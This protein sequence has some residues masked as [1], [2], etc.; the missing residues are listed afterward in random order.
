METNG[1]EQKSAKQ[2]IN[3][4]FRLLSA[5]AI[6]SVVAGHLGGGGFS[7]LYRLFPAYQFHLAT[8]IFISGY[9]YQ[10]K[11]E[12][13][14]LAYIKKKFWH[15][16]VPMYLW[17]LFYGIVVNVLK[18]YDLVTFGEALS[19]KTLVIK[20]LYH[21]HQFVLDLA[22]W[23]VPPLF[24]AEVFTVL[25]RRWLNARSI[26]NEYAIFL[27]YLFIGIVG[28]ELAIHGLNTKAWLLICKTCIFI[29]FFGIGRMYRTKWEQRE[30]SSHVKY[31]AGIL[32]MQIPLRWYFQTYHNYNLG[33]TLS[34]CPSKEFILLGP[35]LPF[36]TATFGVLFW[37]R[38]CKIV[39]PWLRRNWLLNQMGE[40]TFAIMA[41]HLMGAMLVKLLLAAIV[42]LFGVTFSHFDWQ[43]IQSD[44]WYRPVFD[45]GKHLSTI[46][47]VAGIAFSLVIAHVETRVREM[48]QRLRKRKS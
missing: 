47:L 25:F 4:A 7:W 11:Y 32:L 43:K 5:F 15:L 2:N 22:L 27:L 23:F 12:Q 28:T 19:F 26:R 24:F 38:I 3:H 13:Q 44:I 35:V 41:H 42:V 17:N 36:V 39:E 21:G 31:L 33:L 34:W 20:P 29:G 37:L 18:H 30:P 46:Y 14:P 48:F 16:L 1:I 45:T 40:H 8:F 9:F 10:T 6:F